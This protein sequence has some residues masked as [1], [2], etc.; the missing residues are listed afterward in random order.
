MSDRP[1]ILVSNDDGIDAPGLKALVEAVSPLGEVRVVAPERQQ[2]AVGHAITMQQPLRAYPHRRS[3]R[4]WGTA[5]TG[6][7]ADCVKLALAKLLER[8]PDLVVSGINHG[9]NTSTNVLY[10]G[11]VSAAAE[12]ALYGIPSIAF[13]LCEQNWEADLSAARQIASRIAAEV[14]RRG[15]PQGVLLNVN[16]PP[17]PLE[18]IQGIRVTRQAQ[19]RW[20][21][22]FDSRTDPFNRTYYWLTGTFVNFD[23]GEDTDEAA[24]AAG[25]VS[26]TPIHYDLT[27]YAALEELRRW[28]WSF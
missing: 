13:S 12:G 20:I 2:S 18:Q 25:Y 17:L 21:E 8:R 3:G 24:I 10:S 19:A 23:E 16:I 1:L 26:I 22:E 11:T 7:P 28:P 14:L 6:T 9:S 5:V 15:L 4:L 27:A